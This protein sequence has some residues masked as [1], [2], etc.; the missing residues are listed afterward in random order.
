MD[1]SGVELQDRVMQLRI[2]CWCI[3]TADPAQLA[4]FWQ[5]ALGWRRTL[6]Q[7]VEVVLEHRKEARK[8]AWSRTCCSCGFLRRRQA[9][10]AC[11]SICGL[12]I[13]RLR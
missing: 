8:M 13:R 1:G 6:E 2:Q 11:I 5:K 9:R 12:R 3:D 7:D 4:S 10:I